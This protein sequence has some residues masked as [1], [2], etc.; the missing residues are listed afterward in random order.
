MD[1]PES[2]Q[3]CGYETKLT[4]YGM[5]RNFPRE[6]GEKWLCEL[7][8]GTMT[9]TAYEY[10]EQFECVQLMQVVCYIGNTILDA[11]RKEPQS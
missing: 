6:S 8:A 10:P 4:P 11:V 2:C 3:S 5:T 7:C 1:A 9:G